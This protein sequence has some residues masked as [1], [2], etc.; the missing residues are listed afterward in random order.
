MLLLGLGLITSVFLMWISPNESEDKPGKDRQN[1]YLNTIISLLLGFWLESLGSEEESSSHRFCIFKVLLVQKISAFSSL[2]IL[3]NSIAGLWD[4]FIKTSIQ[5]LA[6]ILMVLNA[7]GCGDTRQT[8]WKLPWGKD[9][10][11]S[12]VRRLTSVLVIYIGIRLII[13]I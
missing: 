10:F 2:F 5:I 11:G 3:V 8:D 7:I 12:I 1:I 13:N 6:L 4:S 9:L